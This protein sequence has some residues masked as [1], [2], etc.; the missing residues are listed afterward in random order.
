M[1]KPI[2]F[3]GDKKQPYGCFSQFYYASF[4]DPSSNLTFKC[5]EQFMMYSKAQMAGDTEAASA[6]MSAGSPAAMKAIGR[7]VR[8]FDADEWDRIKCEVVA[9]GNYLK[10][11]QNEGIREVLMG[12]GENMLVEAA[13]NDRIW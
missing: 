1:G 5:A 7:R 13:R 11:S 8:G 3:Y 4:T 9:K 10:F 6:I 2:F 12:T